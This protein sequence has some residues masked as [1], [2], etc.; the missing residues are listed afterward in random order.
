MEQDTIRNESTYLQNFIDKQCSR[1][2]YLEEQV[3]EKRLLVIG[4]LAEKQA[5]GPI[6]V[7]QFEAFIIE[8]TSDLTAMTT[9]KR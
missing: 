1:I 6:D 7:E 2:Q 5:G 9:N 8:H 4:A 3:Q